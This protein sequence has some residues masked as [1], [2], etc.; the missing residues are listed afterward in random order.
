MYS[1]INSSCSGNVDRNGSI[2]F[3]VLLLHNVA[4]MHMLALLFSWIMHCE[5]THIHEN[6]F[7]I[8]FKVSHRLSL[9]YL[10]YIYIFFYIC[11]N[12]IK[13]LNNVQFKKKKK[14]VSLTKIVV[15]VILVILLF[16]NTN[17]Y[18]IIV[19]F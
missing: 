16:S 12:L 14:L 9:F 8:F 2:I 6:T 13:S 11:F 5:Q 19:L 18:V 17:F 1:Q 3:K 15:I 10:K 4:L 7:S